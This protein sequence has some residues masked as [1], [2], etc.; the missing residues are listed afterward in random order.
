MSATHIILPEHNSSRLLFIDNQDSNFKLTIENLTQDSSEKD[1]CNCSDPKFLLGRLNNYI[2]LLEDSGTYDT[3]HTHQANLNYTDQN[4][5]TETFFNVKRIMEYSEECDRMYTAHGGG[6]KFVLLDSPSEDQIVELFI[7]YERTLPGFE[8]ITD[9]QNTETG[10]KYPACLVFYKY[11]KTTNIPQMIQVVQLAAGLNVRDSNTLQPMNNINY[12][13]LN[14]KTV[15]INFNRL[16]FTYSISPNTTNDIKVSFI[17]TNSL[18]TNPNNGNYGKFISQRYYLN[19]DNYI[20]PGVFLVQA[21]KNRSWICYR[22]YYSSGF[23]PGTYVNIV[24][25]SNLTNH[26]YEY[27]NKYKNDG[28][29]DCLCFYLNKSSLNGYNG[30]LENNK[31]VHEINIDRNSDKNVFCLMIPKMFC[32][33]TSLEYLDNNDNVLSNYLDLGANEFEVKDIYNELDGMFYKF[34]AIPIVRSYCKIYKVK[35]TYN[36]A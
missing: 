5:N 22:T 2:W 4:N 11:N 1:K 14:I 28:E 27:S 12:C 36:I 23:S 7:K 16:K 30:T 35:L 18:F 19:N 15:N 34:I 25:K 13:S 21:P 9:L 33:Y 3:N 29:K 6:I 32:N 10:E 26:S 8:A 31:Y 24:T 20:E 17:G